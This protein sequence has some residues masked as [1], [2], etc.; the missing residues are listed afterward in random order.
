MKRD[1]SC[2]IRM[3]GIQDVLSGGAA[4]FWCRAWQLSR[5]KPFGRQAPYGVSD[6]RMSLYN[7]GDYHMRPFEL[8]MAYCALLNELSR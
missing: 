3:Q 8:P 6:P 2:I 5:R 7:K 4:Q 1:F